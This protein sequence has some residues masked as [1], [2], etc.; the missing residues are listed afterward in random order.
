MRKERGGAG[1]RAHAASDPG[2]PTPN[3]R[4]Y[5]LWR[6]IFS[7]SSVVSLW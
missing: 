6:K 3:G 4:A 1:R 7:T 5:R 2:P